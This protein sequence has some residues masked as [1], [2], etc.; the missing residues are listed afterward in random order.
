MRRHNAALCVVPIEDENNTF[1]ESTDSPVESQL[2]SRVARSKRFYANYSQQSQPIPKVQ[3]PKQLPRVFI[4]S[5]R[6]ASLESRVSELEKLLAAREEQWETE[7]VTMLKERED[8]LLELNS[9]KEVLKEAGGQALPKKS[10]L[11]KRSSLCEVKSRNDE[12]SSTA[13]SPKRSIHWDQSVT[14]LE[15]EREKKMR[16]EATFMSLYAA[17]GS[18]LDDYTYEFS[19]NVVTTAVHTQESFSVDDEFTD[20]DS[21]SLDSSSATCN[22]DNSSLDEKVLELTRRRSADLLVETQNVDVKKI[23]KLYEAESLVEIKKDTSSVI[24]ASGRR[25]RPAS[26][27]ISVQGSLNESIEAETQTSAPDSTE[28]K[29]VYTLGSNE[30]H[31]PSV[32]T[33]TSAESVLTPITMEEPRGKSIDMPI[34]EVI[35]EV[36][37]DQDDEK[38][39]REK[40]KKV[41]NWIQKTL[42]KTRS[43]S[44]LRKV[45]SD[46]SLKEKKSFWT[47]K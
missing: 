15:A 26:V 28:E 41:M 37:D 40:P 2:D 39:P 14:V 27:E 31:V 6:E 24:L 23:K 36:L 21:H 17:S 43:A 30:E 32:V 16:V 1:D 45:K 35:F 12:S 10:I 22:A 38:T 47:F 3:V 19:D 18:E 44:S 8:A 33:P 25:P 20:E 4:R 11:R 42:R 9:V 7:R 46:D 5:G 34:R 29:I 13:G